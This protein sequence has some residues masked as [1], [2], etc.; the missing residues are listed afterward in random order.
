MATN[1]LNDITL[2]KD[3]K[4]GTV[5]YLPANQGANLRW[6]FVD[7][8]GVI[9]SAT[10]QLMA[11]RVNI[12]ARCCG[13]NVMQA[14]VPIS[15]QLVNWAQRIIIIDQAN[16]DRITEL[17]A[18][19]PNELAMLQAKSTTIVAPD[20]FF[21]DPDIIEKINQQIPELPIPT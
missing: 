3:I 1:F 14:L 15:L 17:F 13:A 7:E 19:F 10:G 8:R 9:A 11:A 21:N 16:Y 4:D 20:T 12:N 6:L 18:D 5:R 2:R